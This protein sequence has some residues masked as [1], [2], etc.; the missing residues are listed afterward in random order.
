MVHFT[1]ESSTAA[2]VTVVGWDFSLVLFA[3]FTALRLCK[4][5]TAFLFLSSLLRILNLFYKIKLHLPLSSI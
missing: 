1:N 3:V 4:T 2:E 5:Y